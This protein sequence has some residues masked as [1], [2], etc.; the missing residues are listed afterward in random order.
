M[1]KKHSKIGKD[2]RTFLNL[3][4]SV[5]SFNISF[6]YFRKKFRSKHQGTGVKK[7][8]F[9]TQSDIVLIIV[10]L[11]INKNVLITVQYHR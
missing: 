9:T 4:S 10:Q 3:S 6:D 7:E 2:F 1:R 11:N 5:M 8:L